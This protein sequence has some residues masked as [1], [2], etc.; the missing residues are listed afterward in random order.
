M[1]TSTPTQ[2]E[3]CKDAQ[4][5]IA[6]CMGT[7]IILRHCHLFSSVRSACWKMR[8]IWRSLSGGQKAR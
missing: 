6:V 5:A 8:S 3:R 4:A 2:M 7:D 1:S